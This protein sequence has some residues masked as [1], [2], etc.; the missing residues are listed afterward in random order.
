MDDEKTRFQASA[1]QRRERK[2]TEERLAALRRAADQRFRN[3][4]E[5]V[6]RTPA[7]VQFLIGLFHL[8][9]Y[10]RTSVVTRPDTGEVIESATTFNDARRSVYVDVR[11]KI[12][13]EARAKVEALAEALPEETRKE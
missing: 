6:A 13:P 11:A 2:E 8:C 3:A 4:A 9:G 12:S 5:E 10:N 7:G 1:D